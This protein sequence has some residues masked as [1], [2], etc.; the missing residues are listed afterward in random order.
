MS[1]DARG[2]QNNAMQLPFSFCPSLREWH[3]SH[4]TSTSVDGPLSGAFGSQCDSEEIKCWLEFSRSMVGYLSGS[5]VLSLEGNLCDPRG[6]NGI[7]AGCWEVKISSCLCF[8]MIK[9]NVII[10]IKGGGINLFVFLN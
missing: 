6:Y 2:S 8:S 9:L 3:E 5:P 10:I 7:A 4:I 1:C